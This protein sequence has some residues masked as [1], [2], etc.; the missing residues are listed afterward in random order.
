MSAV[1]HSPPGRRIAIDLGERS[2]PIDVGA[3]ILRYAFGR[4]EHLGFGV[5]FSQQNA[6]HT[7]FPDNHF[8]LV[9]SST[10]LHETSRKAV[11]NIMNECYRILKPGGVMIHLE[12]PAKYEWLDMWGRIRGDYEIHYNNEPFW[13]GALSMDFTVPVKAAGFRDVVSGYQDAVTKAEPGAKGFGDTPKGV[14]RCW[15]MV[16]GVK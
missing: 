6:E 9:F 15:Y 13:R 2:Y 5:H 3:G 1:P 16:S 7:D 4:S 12:V 10:V 11:P 8:D 14:H